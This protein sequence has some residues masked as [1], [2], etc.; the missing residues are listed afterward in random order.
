LRRFASLLAA[1]LIA[2][3][4]GLSFSV[5]TAAAQAG[6]GDAEYR[7]L[8]RRALAAFDAKNWREAQLLFSSAHSLQPSA[9]TLRGMGMVAFEMAEYVEAQQMLRAALADPRRPLEDQLRADTETL[10]ARTRALI[11]RVRMDVEPASAELSLDG[12]PLAR[13]TPRELWIKAGR[14]VI[15]ARASGHRPRQV[16][17]TA[18]GGDYQVLEVRLDPEPIAMREPAEPGDE[19]ASS[20]EA[21]LGQAPGDGRDADSD[22]ITA[23]WWFWA[24]AG[25]LA[26]GAGVTVVLLATSGEE[27]E[28]LTRGTDGMVIT[29]LTLP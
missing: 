17:I 23:Q 13:P 18:R 21:S 3:C 27:R 1:A 24:G 11:T 19:H 9:R 6:Q 29:T 25:A 15:E 14:H 12:K 2:W 22:A 20:V 4:G 10:L 28:Q 16:P 8:V 5:E 7:E 26:I